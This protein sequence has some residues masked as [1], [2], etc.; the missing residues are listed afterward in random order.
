MCVG[1]TDFVG[2]RKMLPTK[3]LPGVMKCTRE[4]LSWNDWMFILEKLSMMFAFP[5]AY[6]AH[7]MTAKIMR[8]FF[9]IFFQKLKAES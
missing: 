7:T 4:N 5:I 2:N 9:C 8:I 1:L 6:N 3:S